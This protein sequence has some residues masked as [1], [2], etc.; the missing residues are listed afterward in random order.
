MEALRALGPNIVTPAELDSYLE[1][2]LTLANMLTDQKV[3][4]YKASTK[5]LSNLLDTTNLSNR[6]RVALTVHMLSGDLDDDP[7]EATV[8]L[9]NGEK[10]IS[11]K[12]EMVTTLEDL[13]EPAT[14][15]ETPNLV[16]IPFDSAS[17]AVQ[18]VVTSQ[19][20]L[21]ESLCD[22]KDWLSVQVGK[23]K[24]PKHFRLTKI[25][26]C[27][28]LLENDSSSLIIHQIAL[29]ARSQQSED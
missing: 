11:T 13:D 4:M 3:F 28:S 26:M 24:A 15:L 22:L 21:Y 2:G 7:R 10:E 18:G 6:G 17:K 23:V 8:I 12:E 9:L 20:F 19:S 25:P 1:K 16:I 27:T 29:L 14:V 5:R